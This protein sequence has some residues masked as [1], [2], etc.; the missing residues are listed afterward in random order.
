MNLHPIFVHFPVALLT[1]YALM[2]LLRFRKLQGQPYW[3]YVKALFLMIGG[4]GALAA[5]ATGDAARLA[6]RMGEFHPAVANFSQVVRL[7]E[8]FADLSVAIFG[9]LAASYLILWLDRENFG[10]WL[11][12]AGLQSFWAVLRKMAGL[13]ADSPLSVIL[14]LAG[15]ASI[16]ITGG[17]GGIMV[18][19]PGVDPIFGLFY[20]LLFP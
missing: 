9:L 19:G 6:A 3:F 1:V 12:S 11:G 16:T 10:R 13:L 18:Y 14:A 17:L 5:L 20:R 15:L 8:S 7:H 4:L 2:E